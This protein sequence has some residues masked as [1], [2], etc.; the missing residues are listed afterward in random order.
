MKFMFLDHPKPPS[1]IRRLAIWL[2][3]LLFLMGL[4]ICYAYMHEKTFNK[5]TTG[6]EFGPKHY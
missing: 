5:P 3:S 2:A 6:S 4:L 1:I